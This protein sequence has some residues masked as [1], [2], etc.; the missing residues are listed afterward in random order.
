MPK[1]KRNISEV[2]D[3]SGIETDTK[4]QSKK[5]KKESKKESEPFWSVSFGVPYLRVF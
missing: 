5:S 3:N 4:S 1:A 2:D